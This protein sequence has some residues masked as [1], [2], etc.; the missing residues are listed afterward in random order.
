MSLPRNSHHEEFGVYLGE[1]ISY[2]FKFIIKLKIIKKKKTLVSE[3][4]KFL[5]NTER[6][7]NLYSLTH[8]SLQ[9]NLLCI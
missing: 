9:S 8:A 6:H 2:I 5:T 7:S 4:V 3:S 1:Y